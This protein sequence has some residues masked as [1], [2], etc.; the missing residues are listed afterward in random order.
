M[1]NKSTPC[2]L[3]VIMQVHKIL[4]SANGAI[5][6]SVKLHNF[7]NQRNTTLMSIFARQILFDSAATTE[8]SRKAACISGN[9]R[10]I[11]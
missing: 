3:T 1:K 4:S 11:T 8:P 9:V 7:L 5:Y 2:R 10:Q 6:S